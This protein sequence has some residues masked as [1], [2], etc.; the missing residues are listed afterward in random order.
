MRISQPLLFLSLLSPATNSLVIFVPVGH[1][2]MF[3]ITSFKCAGPSFMRVEKKS[4]NM[5]MMI[6][7]T[8]LA[9]GDYDQ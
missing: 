8:I 7:M 1:Y 6:R 3:S 5:M 2:Y 9:D 4:L